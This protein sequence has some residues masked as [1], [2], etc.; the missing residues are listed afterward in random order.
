[1]LGKDFRSYL[2]IEK[3]YS[4]HTVKA[5]VR[6]LDAFRAFI[7]STYEFDPVSQEDLD[8]VTHRMIRAWMGDLMD[9]GIS[10]RSVARKVASLNGW[11]K[12]LQKTGRLETNPAKKVSVPKYDKKLPAVLQPDSIDTLFQD[13]EYPEGFKGARDKA[14][15]EVLYSCGLRRSEIIGLLFQN[16]S[17]A[18]R[19]LK[20][21]G[22]GRKERVVPFGRAAESS[23]R[24][25]MQAADTEGISYRDHFFVKKDGNKLYPKRVHN[26]VETYLKQASNLSKTSPHVLRHSF[27]T[28]LLDNGA[29][30]NAIKEMLGHSSLAA[31]QVYLHNSISKLKKVYDQAHPKA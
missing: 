26:I 5:Y 15:L 18:D 31:T 28:H 27:A 1:M 22:K 9:E 24:L 16:I 20:V 4:E 11:F 19:T 7:Q 29:D 13:I 30:L 6:D 17:F 3:N 10:K 23:M 14:V 2:E 25:Y 8:G 12:W 21:L